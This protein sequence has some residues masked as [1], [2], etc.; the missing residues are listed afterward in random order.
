MNNNIDSY[1]DWLEFVEYL[2]K[3]P[4][5]EANILKLQNSNIAVNNDLI[6]HLLDAILDLIK[7][8]IDKVLDKYDNYMMDGLNED[9]FTMFILDVKKEFQYL[10]KICSISYIP[11]EI[12]TKLYEELKK[13][14]DLVQNNLTNLSMDLDDDGIYQSIIINNPINGF[15]KE[16]K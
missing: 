5:S 11:N 10:G 9:M 14:A 16:R 2:K 7:T 4:R 6:N 12:M 3:A 13:S 15:Y 8:R 1:S